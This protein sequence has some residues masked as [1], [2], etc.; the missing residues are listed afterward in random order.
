MELEHPKALAEA[1][2]LLE[3][4]IKDGNPHYQNAKEKDYPFVECATMADDIKYGVGPWQS[5]WHFVDLPWFD[6]GGKPEDFP[7]FR[8][9]PHN[10][11][12]VIPEI[13]AWLRNEPGYKESFVYDVMMKHNFTVS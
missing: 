11:T 8:S 10:L 2:Q 1:N 13:M 6:H 7:K 3:L 4:F 12:I 5:D 9:N